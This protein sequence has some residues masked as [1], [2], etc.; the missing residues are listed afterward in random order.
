MQP[1]RAPRKLD[2]EALWDYALRILA[3]RSHSLAEIKQKLS[4]RSES[5]AGVA[6]VLAKLREYGLADDSKFSETFASARLQNQQFG[7]LRVLRDLQAKRV[8]S[9]VAR[10]AIDK[11]FAGVDE[12]ELARQFLQKKYRGRNL[13][14]LF[15]EQR[16]LA[17]AYRRLRSAGFSGRA[18]LDALKAH[19]KLADEI[20]DLPEPE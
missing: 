6:T 9:T 2:P 17:S 1:R 15:Q 5:P 18:A 19:S 14:E 12:T 3:Q 13:A 16:Q 11:T 7:R 8:A 20:D 10:T 4:R